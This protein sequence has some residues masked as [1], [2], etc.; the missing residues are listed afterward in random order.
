MRTL[1][2]LNWRRYGPLAAAAPFAQT[3]LMM[4]ASG[5]AL[6]SLAFGSC[7]SAPPLNVPAVAVYASTEECEIARAVLKEVY[8]GG[9]I[10]PHNGVV[11]WDRCPWAGRGAIAAGMRKPSHFHTLTLARPKIADS[12]ASASIWIETNIAHSTCDFEV[13]ELTRTGG[14]WR[15]QACRP[16]AQAPTIC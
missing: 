3:W 12:G 11:R 16:P 8:R 6:L 7:A 10:T 14:A 9:T 15:L 2:E 1:V 13:C 4:K 5:I